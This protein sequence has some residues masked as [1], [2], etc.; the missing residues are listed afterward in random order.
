ML[1]EKK[2]RGATKD[3]PWYAE[4]IDLE[5]SGNHNK[6]PQSNFL[7]P[8]LCLGGGDV[9]RPQLTGFSRRPGQRLPNI[10][11][12]PQRLAPRLNTYSTALRQNG[13][14]IFPTLTPHYASTRKI[15]EPLSLQATP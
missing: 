11:R 3:L 13:L 4:Y 5:G 7:P 6:I 2:A 12:Q 15:D 10:A 1:I 8:P 9:R 14:G